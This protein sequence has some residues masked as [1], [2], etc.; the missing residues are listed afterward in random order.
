[1]HD[2]VL[3]RVYL[4]VGVLVAEWWSWVAYGLMDRISTWYQRYILAWVVAWDQRLGRRVRQAKFMELA[5]KKSRRLLLP[6]LLYLLT[7]QDPK[8]NLHKAPR[9]KKKKNLHKATCQNQ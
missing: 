1:M 5:S 3:I 2:C 6:G 4:C 9:K 8:P 7:F